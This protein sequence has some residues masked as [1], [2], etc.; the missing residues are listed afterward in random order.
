M[1]DKDAIITR[2]KAEVYDL[3]KQTQYM[4]EILGEVSRIVG[5][6]EGATLEG[7]FEKLNDAF[8]DE[9]PAE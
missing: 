2:L 3:T 7:L 1:E 4:N 9:K 5:V 8:K 6:E